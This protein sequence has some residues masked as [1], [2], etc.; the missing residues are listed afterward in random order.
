MKILVIGEVCTDR[1]VIGNVNRICPEGPVPVLSPFYQHESDGMAGNVVRNFKGLRPEYEMVNYLGFC[2]I[3]TRYIDERSK[4]ILLRVDE[5]DNVDEPLDIRYFKGLMKDDV[6]DAVVI[7]DYNK[8]FLNEEVLKQI[9]D[10]CSVPL[11][12][13]TKKVLGNWSSNFDFVK[14]N[15]HEYSHNKNVINEMG[16]P[17]DFCDTLIVTQGSKGCICFL[18]NG[19]I[20]SSPSYNRGIHDVSGAGDSFLVGFVVKYLETVNIQESMDFAN[21]VAAIAV[22]KQGVAIVTQKEID[23]LEKNITLK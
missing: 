23:I 20:I 13:D 6:Y 11:F 12:I 18:P 5:K 3:K 16:G 19:E 8:G 22:S 15:E 1:F 17:E 10:C 9:S 21:K 14:I 4:Y 2:G 7:S